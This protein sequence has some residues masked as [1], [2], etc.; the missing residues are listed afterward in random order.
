MS[1]CDQ[2]LFAIAVAKRIKSNRVS[3]ARELHVFVIKTTCKNPAPH[4]P[5]TSDFSDLLE[6]IGI[7]TQIGMLN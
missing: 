6:T 2:K 4:C 5:A 1:N 7:A 3:A